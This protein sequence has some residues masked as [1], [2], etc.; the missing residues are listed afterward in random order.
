MNVT[1]SNRPPEKS[2][3]RPKSTKS[4]SVTSSCA[5]CRQPSP[6]DAYC[7][8]SEY[9]PW[10]AFLSFPCLT[11]SSQTARGYWFG[12]MMATIPQVEPLLMGPTP[13]RDSASRRVSLSR[14]LNALSA[15]FSS[16]GD[17]PAAEGV[18][19]SGIDM[20]CIRYQN[21]SVSDSTPLSA[22]KQ[23]VARQ[24]K[25][26]RRIKT[27]GPLQGKVRANALRLEGPCSQGSGRQSDRRRFEPQILWQGRP[28]STIGSF[29]IRLFS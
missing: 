3:C 27:D 12:G 19:D 8:T 17:G 2:C 9:I 10:P 4:I 1:T 18:A 15:S 6:T 7:S 14:F 13:I 24:I 16:W 25:S 21:H 26:A 11:S 5:C 20:V 29:L 23:V 22:R 28:A